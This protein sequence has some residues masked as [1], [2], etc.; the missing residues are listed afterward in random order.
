[1]SETADWALV[2]AAKEGDRLAFDAL[3]GPLIE[4]GYRLAFGML[5]DRAEA[6]DVVQEAAL[7]AWRKLG[8]LQGGAAMR[9]WFLGI[10]ANQCRSTR[11]ARW[12]SVVKVAQPG[13]PA[14]APDAQDS[15]GDELRQAL[16]RLD[17]RQR[18]AVVLHFYLDLSQEEVARI[19]GVPVGTVKSRISRGV[20]RLRVHLDPSEALA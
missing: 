4:P 5:H 10:V 14:V 2:Q 15:S 11:R 12:W 13:E 20:R 6:E 16:M 1:V 7:K 17:P 9:P 8:N 3:V 19:L 18:A